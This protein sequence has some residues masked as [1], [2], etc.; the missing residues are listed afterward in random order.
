MDHAW[1]VRPDVRGLTRGAPSTYL[2]RLWFD[3]CVFSSG[4]VDNLVRTVG[5]DRVM[6]GSDYPFDIGSPDPVGLV[7]KAKLSDTD[8]QK[9]LF[10][11]ASRL[12]KIA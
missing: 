9:V 11:N 7:N 10:G 6:M 8:R 4:L 3:T 12:F 2:K 1:K 5:V